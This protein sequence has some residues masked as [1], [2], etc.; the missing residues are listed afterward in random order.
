MQE[1]NQVKNLIKISLVAAVYVVLTVGFLPISYGNI[2]FR[3]SEVLILF[4]FIDKKYIPGLVLGCAI[5]NFYSPLGM[6]D[7][8][9]GTTATLFSLIAISK[10]KNLFLASLWPVVFNGLIVGAELK[11]AFGLPYLLTAAQV[12]V[13]EFVVVSLAGVAVFKLLTSKESFLK[14]ISM[15]S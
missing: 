1:S 6:L 3:I 5:A 11:Y 9:F 8:V 10:T 4:A 7:V 2:Q 12:A 15:Q 14:V 13:G